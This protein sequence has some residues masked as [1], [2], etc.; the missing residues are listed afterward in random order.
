MRP[1]HRP[2]GTSRCHAPTTTATTLARTPGV[3]FEVRGFDLGDLPTL[4]RAD[5]DEGALRAVRRLHGTFFD[6]LDANGGRTSL[7]DVPAAGRAGGQVGRDT[8][9]AVRLSGWRPPVSIARGR[10]PERRLA[11]IVGPGSFGTSSTAASPSRTSGQRL[12]VAEVSPD[13]NGFPR[14]P[15]ARTPRSSGTSATSHPG[16]VPA[17]TGFGERGLID[18][19]VA[20]MLP[21]FC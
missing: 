18:V 11:L 4:A 15:P 3:V 16:L 14:C 6:Q 2:L 13:R 9:A 19:L 7:A 17:R 5:S 21:R 12:V 20:D 1:R 8:P 10:L